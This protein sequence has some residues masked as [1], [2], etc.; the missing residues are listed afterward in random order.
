MSWPEQTDREADV[1]NMPEN[2]NPSRA[3]PADPAGLID[4]L[5]GGSEL[6]VV[7]SPDD[8]LP[9]LKKEPR[10]LET[11]EL[12]IIIASDTAVWG[13]TRKTHVSFIPGESDILVSYFSYTPHRPYYGMSDSCSV[14]D[15]IKTK[16]VNLRLL[17]IQQ[18]SFVDFKL[19]DHFKPVWRLGRTD[20]LAPIR[21]AIADGAR[22]R[23]AIRV[24]SGVWVIAPVHIPYWFEDTSSFKVTTDYDFLPNA[25]VNPVGFDKHLQENAKDF[26]ESDT[27][28]RSIDLKLKAVFTFV[29]LYSDG[30][31]HDFSTIPTGD[32]KMVRD[33]ILFAAA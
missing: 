20:D 21:S 7:M 29:E 17:P 4:A 27:V 8:T 1:N 26:V 15:A 31:F 25:F 32:R 33:A 2:T 16:A 9:F 22:F 10:Y 6:R 28:A 12:P 30:S 18:Y 14:V 23:L 5:L 11:I 19:V 24:D 13:S 3:I